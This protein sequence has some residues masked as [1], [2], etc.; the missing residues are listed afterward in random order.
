[1][2]FKLRSEE[3]SQGMSWSRGQGDAHQKKEQHLQRFWN[4]PHQAGRQTP[5]RSWAR[6]QR[7]QSPSGGPRTDSQGWSSGMGQRALLPGAP[8]SCWG[9]VWLTRGRMRQLHQEKKI[10]GFAGK[11]WRE[12]DKANNAFWLILHPQ[13]ALCFF[14][15]KGITGYLSMSDI[16]SLHH[17]FH[18]CIV[19]HCAWV[20]SSI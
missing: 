8:S 5:C 11:A 2:L 7:P 20:L 19:L 13:N 18:G 4:L 16:E 1:M 10:Y 3:I 9:T 12:S 6:A 14:S 17:P 15:H